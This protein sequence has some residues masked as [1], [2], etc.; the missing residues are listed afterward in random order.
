[1]L[2]IGAG[3]LAEYLATMAI[4]NDFSVTVCD[5]RI[6]HLS[7]L[8]VAGVHTTQEMPDDAVLA[9]RPDPRTCIVALS[10]DPKLDDLALLEALRSPA[11]YV[12]AIG[13]RRNTRSRSNDSLTISMKPKRRCSGCMHRG[14]SLSVAK[15]PAEIAVSIM[16]EILAI[17]NGITLP[18]AL[19]VEHVKGQQQAV[20]YP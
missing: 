1:M 3:M 20:A 16:A 10:H 6:E 8:S 15:T 19:S 11:F 7:N 9:L 5:P 2:L 12:G 17:K 13:S 18:A 4:F 14:A